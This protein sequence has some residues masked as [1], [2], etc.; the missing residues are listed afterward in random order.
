MYHMVQS[1]K[2]MGIILHIKIKYMHVDTHNI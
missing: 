2:Y 1:E